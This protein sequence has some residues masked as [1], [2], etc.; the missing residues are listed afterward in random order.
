MKQADHTITRKSLADEVADRLRKLITSG[1]YNVGDKLPTEP[2]LMEQFGVGRSSIREAVRILAN[3]GIVRVQQGMGTFVASLTGSADL[4]SGQLQRAR[5]ED[6]N[7]VRL[8]LEEKIVEKAVRLRTEADIAQ[9]RKFVTLRQT[10][11]QAGD[12]ENCIQA[13]IDFHTAIAEAAQNPIMTE[14]Y[15]L[16]AKHV[17]VSFLQRHKDVSAFTLSQEL[18]ENLLQAIIDQD[19][20]QALTL[21]Q[22]IAREKK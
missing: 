2:R 16:V 20:Q 1:D 18:H 11:A 17:K 12:L 13:D 3:A 9:M 10:Y 4:L 7:E 22:N 19:Y 14:L 15:Q 21:A 5:F 8:L 6:V